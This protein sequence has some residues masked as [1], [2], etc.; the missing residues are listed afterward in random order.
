MEKT[1]NISIDILKIFMA[2]MVVG[3]HAGFLGDISRLFEYIFVNGIFRVAVPIFFIINGFYFFH[4]DRDKNKLEWF[5]KTIRLYLVWMTFYSYAWITKFKSP[6]EIIINSI[7]TLAIGYH[8]LWYMVG[9]VGA[10]AITIKLNNLRL[11]TNLIV[12]ILLFS[13]GV[14]I[15]YCGNYN[16]LKSA[17]T[18]NLFNLHW[19]HRNFLFF[20]FPFFYIGYAINKYNLLNKIESQ[21]INISVLIGVVIL[22]IESYI[23]FFQENRIGGFDNY[24]SLIII[25]PSI[26]LFFI[27]KNI[28]SSNKNISLYSSS[29]YFIH[30]F[31]LDILRKATYFEN[32]ILT[33]SGLILSI[34][35][36]YILVNANKRIKF[37]L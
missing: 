30:V 11:Q 24:A 14:T 33:F 25:C 13:L 22:I 37:I 2:T 12:A 32:T 23:N 3:L 26:F 29:I 4:A 19:T 17:E 16:L 34:F 9:M 20:A 18:N 7:A 10:A 28:P 31:A 8:H 5:K 1:R 36:S 35:L 27:K 15:Q 6:E 21:Y